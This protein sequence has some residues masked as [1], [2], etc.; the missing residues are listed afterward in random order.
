MVRQSHEIVDKSRCSLSLFASKSQNMR[1]LKLKIKFMSQST[2]T[3]LLRE[4]S[5]M[6]PPDPKPSAFQIK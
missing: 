6:A 5:P 4:T 1:A 2:E 3:L